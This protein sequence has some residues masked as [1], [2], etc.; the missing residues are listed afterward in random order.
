MAC[1]CDGPEKHE[2][3]VANS[4]SWL[5]VEYRSDSKSTSI[6]AC[7]DYLQNGQIGQNGHLAILNDEMPALIRVL[8]KIEKGLK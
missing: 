4:L 7:T 8:Q 1:D 6:T 2:I 3:R 5:E